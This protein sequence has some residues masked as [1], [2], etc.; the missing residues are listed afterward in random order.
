MG[1]RG[2]TILVAEDDPAS[3]ELLAE[4]LRMAGYEV[5][6]ASDGEEAIAQAQ[7]VIPDLVLVDIQ[8]P[9]RDGFEVLAFV[10][11]HFEP[12]PPVMAIT[13]HAMRGDRE[14]ALARGF[15]EYFTKPIEV[16]KLRH[17]IGQLL[18]PEPPAFGSC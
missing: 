15:E 8:M 14:R 12:S 18:P 5:I 4:I 7:L 13:A 17:K 10:R 11:Q 16:A 3:R 2:R 9:R 6:E 1:T